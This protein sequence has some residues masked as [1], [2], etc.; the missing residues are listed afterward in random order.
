M[1]GSVPLELLVPLVAH[2]WR[3]PPGQALFGDVNMV[4]LHPLW[5]VPTVTA[6]DE[7]GALQEKGG[8]GHNRSLLATQNGKKHEEPGQLGPFL[9][10]SEQRLPNPEPPRGWRRQ[11]WSPARSSS[12]G[13]GSASSPAGWRPDSPRS[14][15]SWPP[16][17]LPNAPGNHD[18]LENKAETR[19]GVTEQFFVE[20]LFEATRPPSTFNTYR[21][22]K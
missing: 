18:V 15:S 16:D 14:C 9:L 19:G 2:Y 1:F 22:E 21:M 7:S 10:T 17:W 4:A 5:P 6:V 8:A 12:A 3:A 20:K 13:T 11:E